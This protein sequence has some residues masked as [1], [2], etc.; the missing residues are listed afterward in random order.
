M[1][2]VFGHISKLIPKLRHEGKRPRIGT[3][4]S[5]KNKVGGLTPR[6]HV[7]YGK[8]TVT[9]QC[10]AGERTEKQ[11]HRTN[12]P[13]AETREDGQLVTDKGAGAKLRAE[14]VSSASSAGQS[15]RPPADRLIWMQTLHLSPK[16]TQ[17][18]PQAYM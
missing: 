6:S 16:L 12:S 7:A 9:T 13:D 18:G 17:N 5:K 2:I 8:A 3:S 1:N 4:V 10:G 14:T 15:G 11:S